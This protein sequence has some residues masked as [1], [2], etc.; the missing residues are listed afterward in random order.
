MTNESTRSEATFSDGQGTATRTRDSRSSRLADPPI[1]R[2][3]GVWDQSEYREGRGARKN[4][5]SPGFFSRV[6]SSQWGLQWALTHI[7]SRQSVVVVP[8]TWQV[9]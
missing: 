7:Q 8:H 4:P 2:G 5:G 6:G 3:P 1:R 9:R